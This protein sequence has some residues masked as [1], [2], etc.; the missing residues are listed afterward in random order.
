MENKLSLILLLLIIYSQITCTAQ[1]FVSIITEAEKME[2]TT[3]LYSKIEN[4]YYNEYVVIN[5]NK[6]LEKILLIPADANK[7]MRSIN[8]T[9]LQSI[10]TAI[11][12]ISMYYKHPDKDVYIV[13]V[14]N[15]RYVLFINIAKKKK[16]ALVSYL[17]IT[18][19]RF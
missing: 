11:K 4:I 2:T 9:E 19:K 14:N 7:M 18:I 8:D 16:T 17:M 10:V 5:E 3:I 6:N 13:S 1:T 15:I 12:A